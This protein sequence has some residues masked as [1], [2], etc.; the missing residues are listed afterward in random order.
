VIIREGLEAT[1]LR[2]ISREGGFTTGVL[3][4]YFPDKQALIAGTFAATSRDWIEYAR[5][6]LAEGAT[7]PQLLSAFVGVAVPREPERR[8]EWRLWAE[9]WTYA[10]RDRAFVAELEAADALW[11]REIHA[12]LRRVRD[13]GFLPAGLDLHMEAAVLARLVDG[14]GLRAWLSGSWEHAR[15]LLIGH[16]ASLGLPLRVVAGLAAEGA[17]APA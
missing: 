13:E 2:D 3:T 16:L 10:G 15:S 17:G 11:E 9:M 8:A 4:H 14:L 7:V 6:A 5:A 1:T 12:M